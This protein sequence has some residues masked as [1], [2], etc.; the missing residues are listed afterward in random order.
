MLFL[1]ALPHATLYEWDLG[2]L[3][4]SAKN[5]ALFSRIY[6]GRFHYYRGDSAK[7]VRNFITNHPNHKCDVVFVDG[8]KG[9]HGR[10]YDVGLFA[11][12]ATPR[13]MLFGDEANTRECMSGEVDERHPLCALRHNTEWAWNRL[14]RSDALK[15]HNCSRPKHG[16]WSER[17][18]VCLWSYT[19]QALNSYDPAKL[20]TPTEIKQLQNKSDQWAGRCSL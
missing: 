11:P 15:W 20:L 18:I 14:V 1:D 5:A 9:I 16:Q 4:Y 7:T 10:L 6:A 13:T 19:Y 2:D 12:L 3:E 8:C 17:D